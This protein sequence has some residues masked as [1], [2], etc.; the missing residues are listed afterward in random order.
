VSGHVITALAPW[1]GGKRTMAAAIVEA[2]GPHT[3]YWEPFCGSMA[4]LLAKPPCRSETANDLHGDLI[5]LARVIRD[6]RLGPALYRLR[7]TLFHEEVFRDSQAVV[8][9]A[10]C[11][12]R[13]APDVERA[14]HYFV[15]SWM[16]MSGVA[17]TSAKSTNFARRYSDKGG[18]PGTRWVSAVRSIPEWRRRMGRVQILSMD[19][20]ALL[21]RI[22]DEPGTAIYCD[23]PYLVKGAKYVH[24]FV[25]K[26]HTRLAEALGRFTR[27]RVVVSYYD[28]PALAGLY[29]GWRMERIDVAKNLVNQ[30]RRD[31]A[32]ATR[33][34]EVLLVN[35]AARG[36]SLAFG[37]DDR[38]TE[39]NDG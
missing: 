29:P 11:D 33:A 21:A 16:G 22:A 15:Q 18:A 6:P 31:Q 10:G 27:A 25:P 2:I 9:A 20:F 13:A 35:G 3:S 39:G 23:P 38:D 30:G 1:F 8:R 28:H 37:E 36:G 17:G 26:D 4:V 24:D 34:P 12:P 32:G 19:A 14:Y 5:N 7:R